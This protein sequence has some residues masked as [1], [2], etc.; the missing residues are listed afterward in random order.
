MPV[1]ACLHIRVSQISN[2]IAH[3]KQI[4][5]LAVADYTLWSTLCVCDVI[6]MCVY[7]SKG[8]TLLSSLKRNERRWV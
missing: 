5:I 6:I 2:T 7:S 1:H 3:I 8:L 4:S